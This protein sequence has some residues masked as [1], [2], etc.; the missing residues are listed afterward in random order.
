MKII[1]KVKSVVKG[2]AKAFMAPMMEGT[3]LVPIE[4]RNSKGHL[5]N[6]ELV[7]EDRTVMTR[8]VQI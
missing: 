6:F 8:R 3:G 4:M 1:K 2:T 5:V 7:H